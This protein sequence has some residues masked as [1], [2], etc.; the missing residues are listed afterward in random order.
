[1][2]I[3]DIEEEGTG[4]RGMK[5]HVAARTIGCNSEAGTGAS[6]RVGLAFRAAA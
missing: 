5:T 4:R 2:R 1:M 6:L 3:D